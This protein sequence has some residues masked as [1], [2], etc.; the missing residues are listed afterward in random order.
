MHVAARLAGEAVGDPLLEAV[1]DLDPDAPFLR[2]RA[3]SAAPLSLPF[4][5]MP[6]P[7]FSNSLTAYSRMSP[8]GSMVGT[9]ATTTTSPLAALKRAAQLDRSRVRCPASMTCAKSLTGAVSSGRR[10]RLRVERRPC[11]GQQREHGTSARARGAANGRTGLRAARAGYRASTVVPPIDVLRQALDG[12]EVA[13]E[14][15]ARRLP[16]IVAARRRARRPP[17]GCRRSRAS[18]RSTWRAAAP[19][20]SRRAPSERATLAAAPRARRRSHD[21]T[22]SASP[23]PRVSRYPSRRCS[24]WLRACTSQ[25]RRRS[26]ASTRRP[27][28]GSLPDDDHVVGEDG[29]ELERKRVERAAELAGRRGAASRGPRSCQPAMR[30][31]QARRSSGVKRVD[32]ASV[33]IGAGRTPPAWP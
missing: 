24:R 10:R 14:T 15:A 6:R 29:A 8:Y 22:A 11:S 31:A 33:G 20:S 30:A 32:E 1:A 26:A 23:R 25:A 4:S 12:V 19:A 13:R 3:G 18:A 7:W 2:A 9:V 27:S 17:R 16:E 5:P 28:N 21:E